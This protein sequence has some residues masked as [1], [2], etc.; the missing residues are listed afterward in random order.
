M[1]LYLHRRYLNTVLAHSLWGLW[2]LVHIRFVWAL[3]AS[4]AGKGVTLNAILPLL[5]SCWGFSF[6]LGRGVSF[7]VGSNIL[8]LTI[9]QQWVVVLKFS[10]E[11]M[12]LYPST[13]P[14]YATN[15]PHCQKSPSPRWSLPHCN[16]IWRWRSNSRQRSSS[17][18]EGQEAAADK[19]CRGQW[20]RCLT[21]MEASP[22]VVPR[23]QPGTLATPAGA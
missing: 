10:Q 18:A 20:L 2:I 14:S 19:G 5:P 8:Q 9:V 17:S 16:L 15:A 22:R 12:S 7:L 11:K 4:L 6:A 1:Y 3:W 21:A 13:P 23:P